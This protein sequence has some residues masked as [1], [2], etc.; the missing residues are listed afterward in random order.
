MNSELIKGLKIHP[1]FICAYVYLMLN[2]EA[3]KNNKKK[4]LTSVVFGKGK[5]T[6]IMSSIGEVFWTASVNIFSIMVKMK[7]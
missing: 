4:Y 1:I 6:L 5:S 2:L 7:R 3:P